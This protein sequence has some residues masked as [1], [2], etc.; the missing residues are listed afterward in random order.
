MTRVTRGSQPFVFP[1]KSQ[2][3]E[4]LP[5][6]EE[7]VLEIAIEVLPDPAINDHRF[8]QALISTGAG[9]SIL[10]Y[11]SLPWSKK[12]VQSDC[13]GAVHQKEVHI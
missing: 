10:Y 8:F 4:S 7:L 1:E 13:H 6:S 2:Q 12:Q 3:K 5:S 11:D 9:G